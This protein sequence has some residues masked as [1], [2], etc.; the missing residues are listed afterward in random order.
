MQMFSLKNSHHIKSLYYNDKIIAYN[1]NNILSIYSEYG[2]SVIN[3]GGVWKYKID[4]I[5]DYDYI[6]F[7]YPIIDIDIDNE[8]DYHKFLEI[9]QI[10]NYKHEQAALHIYDEPKI[11]NIKAIKSVF[12]KHLT[13]DYLLNSVLTINILSKNKY[14]TYEFN[15]THEYADKIRYSDIN[16]ISIFNSYLYNVSLHNYTRVKNARKF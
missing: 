15:I 6:T 10:L 14:R 7:D 9:H 11:D 5:Y 8:D 12:V 16:P 13:N 3:I 4:S 1:N 2:L